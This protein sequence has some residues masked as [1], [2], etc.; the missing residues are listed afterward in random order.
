MTDKIVTRPKTADE[1]VWR[2]EYLLKLEQEGLTPIKEDMVSPR[3]SLRYVLTNQPS[4]SQHHSN[5]TLQTALEI[6]QFSPQ[7]TLRP[8]RVIIVTTMA[9]SHLTSISALVD[10]EIALLCLLAATQFHP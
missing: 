9:T 5:T 10:V 1:R 4:S 6:F 3:K 7:H 2:N 8:P